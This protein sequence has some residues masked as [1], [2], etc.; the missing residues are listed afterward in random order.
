MD[1]HR[2]D[3]PATVD[4]ARFDDEYARAS[5][6]RN[7]GQPVYED[8][9]DGFYDATIEDVHLGQTASTGNPMIVWRLRIRGPQCEG[10]ALTK[11][12]II[13]QKTLGFLKRDLEHLE[14]RLDRLSELPDRTEEMIDRGVRIYKKSNPERRWTDVYFVS[15]RKGPASETSDRPGWLTGTDDDLPF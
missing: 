12:R 9:P 14:I 8:I 5:T 10:R 7:D 15:A 11:V 3:P 13:T 1:S 4:L 6:S 2:T